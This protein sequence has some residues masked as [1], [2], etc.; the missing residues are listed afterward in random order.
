[1]TMAPHHAS[2]RQQDR[3]KLILASLILSPPFGSARCRSGPRPSQCHPSHRVEHD[4]RAN[5]PR[6]P[7]PARR[8][9]PWLHMAHH[10]RR[11]PNRTKA[12]RIDA[13]P[14]RP[15]R[16]A[17]ARPHGFRPSGRPKQCGLRG[18]G[19]LERPMPRSWPGLRQALQVRAWKDR[20]RVLPIAGGRSCD[21][22]ALGGALHR[23][24]SRTQLWIPPFSA[25]M[26]S[27]NGSTAP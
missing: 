15:S 19:R 16:Y 11:L 26:A 9:Q 20:T 1:M 3:S 22:N 23:Q 27:R 8:L 6:R 13:M 7:A 2:R 14:D 21:G 25:L 12:V 4:S 17:L 24:R 10:L 18:L 5:R